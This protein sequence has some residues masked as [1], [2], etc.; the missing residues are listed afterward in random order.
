MKIKISNSKITVAGK[1]VIDNRGK[2]DVVL[3]SVSNSFVCPNGCNEGF[4]EPSKG[5]VQCNRCAY[6]EKINDC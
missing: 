4:I 2:E 1:T 6:I 3:H 5:Y